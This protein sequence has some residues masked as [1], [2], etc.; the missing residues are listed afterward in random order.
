MNL[1]LSHKEISTLRYL[2]GLPIMQCVRWVSASK[3]RKNADS[4]WGRR[5]PNME[6]VED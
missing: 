3:R 5:C 2:N 1:I 4:G 6:Q